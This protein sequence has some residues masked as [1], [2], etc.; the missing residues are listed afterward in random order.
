M[1]DDREIKDL[2]RALE[3]IW[4]I[5]ARL[6]LDPFPTRFEIVPATVMYEI[7]SYAL[8]GRYSHWTFGKAYHRMKTMYD[9]GLSKIYEVV[10][11]TNPSYGFLLET[12]SPI[13]NKLVMAH[14]L[15]HVDFFKHN[16]YFSKTNRRMVESVSSH[17]GRMSEYEFK[18]GRKTVEEFLDA[19][20]SIEEHIDPNFFIKQER[21]PQTEEQ[22]AAGQ[23]KEG[24]YDD[25]WKIGEHVAPPAPPARELPRGERLPEKDLLYYIMRNS[26]ALT[27]WQRDAMG[28]I[29]EEMEYFVPQMQTKT[30]NEGWACATGDSLLLT[31]AGFVRFDELY[32][33]GRKIRVA[34]GDA[35]GLYRINDFH[36]ER[37]VP[38]LRIRTRRGLTIEGA[39]KHRLMLSDG[40]WAYL[41]DIKIGD[42]LH[43][44]AG[45]R[46]WPSKQPTLTF[47]PSA[48]SAT[49]DTV[50]AQAGVSSWTI[51]RH[52]R[53]R[54]TLKSAEIEAAMSATDYRAGMAGK[55]LG[56]RS[57]LNAPRQLS[58]DLSWLLGF[59]VGDG[60]RTKSGICLTCGDEELVATLAGI[61]ER[62]F[63]LR[64]RVKWDATETGG[65]WRVVVHS[66]ELLRWLECFGID[67]RAKSP[68]KRI[69]AHILRSPKAIVSAFLRGYFDADAYAGREGVRLSS[70]SDEL[71][72]TVQLVLLNYGIL[73]TQRPQRDGCTQLEIAGA[74]AAIFLHEIGFSLTRKQRA[75][76]ECVEGHR[77]FRKELVSDAVVSVEYGCADVYDITVD[78]KHAYV[79]NGF[80]NHNSFW[81][82]RIMRELELTDTESIEFAELH[83]GVVSPHKGQLNPYY[84]GYKILE[85]IERRWD[86]PTAAE[87]E[88]FGRKG[89]EGR[90]KIFEVRELD[91]DVSFLRN[92]LTEELCEELDLFV[93]ELVEEEEWTV[94][95]KRWER[96]R[97]QL[98]SNLTNFGFPYI[99]VADGD[100]NRNRELYLK[101]QSE[102]AELDANY[103]RKVLEYVFRL[104]G[105]PVHLETTAD[106]EQVVM[107]YNGEEHEED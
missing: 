5:A 52:L 14:V 46:I 60:N 48:P 101:H 91:N 59:F 79:A 88:Q 102:G 47:Q 16:A 78:T 58:D 72:R 105:R 53:G 99:V 93:Y 75:L 2:E 4:E 40:T 45:N 33:T 76:R 62:E 85:D 1:A 94:T 90:E 97:D 80:V 54:V 11:N 103:A 37:L 32:E 82:S 67:L 71:I 25:L 6:G 13:Q 29:R 92:Y 38:T 69:P 50:A 51:L 66:R 24:R 57:R 95:E 98:V 74:S 73:S 19:V 87:R 27:D 10:I 77:W 26:P 20:L 23:P 8:P 68:D 21:P 107:R 64:A 7:G 12:N 18:Y 15:G 42:E 81:H 106:G 84:L 36:R 34:G 104:W 63:G 89:G 30:L 83:A 86:N 65:R 56:S 96:V 100:Y 3:Q 9:F 31:E 17:A 35:G 41:S 55:V 28:M 22:R 49:L 70:S 39:L 43:V 61:I 44:E